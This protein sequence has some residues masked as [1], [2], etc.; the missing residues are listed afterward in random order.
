MFRL[1][2]RSMDAQDIEA[3]LKAFVADLDVRGQRVPLDRVIRAHLMLFEA[4]RALRLTWPAIAAFVMYA[5]GRRKDGGPIYRPI[6]YEPMSDACDSGVT[7]APAVLKRPQLSNHRVGSV[8]VFQFGQAGD[9]T[10]LRRRKVCRRATRK[11]RSAGSRHF[12]GCI[13]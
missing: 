5:G 2:R 11:S 4:L 8:R 3:G 10:G 7:S 12:Q 9:R 1:Y 13:R 6:R